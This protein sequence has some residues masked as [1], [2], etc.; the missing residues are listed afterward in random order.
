MQVKSPT[1]Y[2]DSFIIQQIFKKSIYYLLLYSATFQDRFKIGRALSQLH[3]N[4]ETFYRS[5]SRWPGASFDT[6]KS[7]PSILLQKFM[8]GVY[9]TYKICQA[10]P[11]LFIECPL[12]M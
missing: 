3:K 7:R 9:L 4:Y 12:Q 10:W 2:F 5:N 11:K 6:E 1:H 8:L